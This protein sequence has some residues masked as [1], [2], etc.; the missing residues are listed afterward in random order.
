[1][2]RHDVAVSQLNSEYGRVFM[3]VGNSNGG[4]L[5]IEGSVFRSPTYLM[6]NRNTYRLV[7]FGNREWAAEGLR[8]FTR[9]YECVWKIEEGKITCIKGQDLTPTTK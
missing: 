8:D 4:S 6:L 1:M 5:D 3:N 7:A 2:G 9:N